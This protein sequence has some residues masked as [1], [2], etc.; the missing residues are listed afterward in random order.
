MAQ[1]AGE[2]LRPLNVRRA[3]LE[4]IVSKEELA[5]YRRGKTGDWIEIKTTAGPP[6]MGECEPQWW[7]AT[8]NCERAI[9]VGEYSQNQA[10]F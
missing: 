6:L 9:D 2:D 8:R 4:G 5:P 1:L 3:D 7:I 10:L